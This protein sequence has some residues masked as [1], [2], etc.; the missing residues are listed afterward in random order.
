MD[1]RILKTQKEVMRAFTE[2][3]SEKDFNQITIN[4]IADRADVSRGTVYLHYIDKYDLLDKCMDNYFNKL[5]ESCIPLDDTKHLPSKHLIIHAF[6]YL[7]QH[8]SIYTALLINKGISPFRKRMLA[9]IQES[10]G[11]LVDTSDINQEMNREVLIQF[12]SSAVVGVLEWWIINSLP[13]P[14]TD[15]VKQLWSMLERFQLKPYSS[16]PPQSFV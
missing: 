9:A 7:E 2:L 3:L 5:F 10:I 16:L 15:M 13:V 6:E 8:A 14:A 12:L 1:R 11:E 4:E